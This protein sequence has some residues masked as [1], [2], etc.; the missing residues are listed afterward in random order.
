MKTPLDRARPLEV[1]AKWRTGARTPEWE[2]LWRRIMS[3]LME[4]N[5]AADPASVR[6]QS[7]KEADDAN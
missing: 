7:P 4:G 3:A 2:R 6:T 5:R 1:T